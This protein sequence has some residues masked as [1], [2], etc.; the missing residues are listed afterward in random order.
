[1]EKIIIKFA[2]EELKDLFK[3]WITDGG[4][5]IDIYNAYDG[6]GGVEVCVDDND[7]L[8]GGDSIIIRETTEEE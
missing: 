1:M 7:L 6:M 3:G 5:D 8:S 2:N 4:G